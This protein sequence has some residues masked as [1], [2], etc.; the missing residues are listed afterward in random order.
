MSVINLNDFRNEA[1]TTGRVSASNL[2]NSN[3][4]KA[5]VRKFPKTTYTLMAA[6][7]RDGYFTAEDLREDRNTAGAKPKYIQMPGL[8][9]TATLLVSS[10]FSEQA[11]ICKFRELKVVYNNA[12]TGAEMGFAMFDLLSSSD[13]LYRNSDYFCEMDG[14]SAAGMDFYEI[15]VSNFGRISEVLFASRAVGYLKCVEFKDTARDGVGMEA[16][17]LTMKHLSRYYG[18]QLFVFEAY[19]IQFEMY[20]DE[21]PPAGETISSAKDFNSA[22]RKLTQLYTKKLGARKLPSGALAVILDLDLAQSEEN[23]KLVS[24]Y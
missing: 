12:V 7:E 8:P 16:L 21:A 11:E 10:D 18:T 17:H 22:K 20:V 19:P 6:R 2:T 15:L 9:L 1:T 24:I 5:D 23:P 14:H 13:E 3:T 4:P